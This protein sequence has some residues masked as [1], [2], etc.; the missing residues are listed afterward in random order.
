MAIET[1]INEAAF[2]E[3][4]GTLQFLREE[5]GLP[6]RPF[7]KQLNFGLITVLKQV[8]SD[9]KQN[10]S[11]G[12][13]TPRRKRTGSH[14]RSYRV[15][16]L[17]AVRSRRT[18]K[19]FRRFGAEINVTGTRLTNEELRTTRGVKLG[20]ALGIEYGN[21][22]VRNPIAPLTTAAESLQPAKVRRLIITNLE[23]RIRARTRRSGGQFDFNSVFQRRPR[24]R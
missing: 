18:G 12:A 5:T 13:K 10:I 4:Y 8:V 2:R 6:G 19:F 1:R 17:K 11:A 9:A 3:M 7:L 20:S 24:S 15:R 22:N 14:E 21:R 23:R 16:G